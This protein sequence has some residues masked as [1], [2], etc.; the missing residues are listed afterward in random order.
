ML[1]SEAGFTLAPTL[2]GES[3]GGPPEEPTEFRRVGRGGGGGAGERSCGW[4]GLTRGGDDG[5]RD[6]DG[7]AVAGAN[8]EGAKVGCVT[9]LKNGYDR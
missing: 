1:K 4:V 2:S 5:G 8:V 9:R 6:D 7:S 3:F